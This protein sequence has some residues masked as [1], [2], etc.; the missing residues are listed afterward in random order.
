MWWSLGIGAAGNIAMTLILRTLGPNMMP[1][2][3]LGFALIPLRTISVPALSLGYI[4]R[5]IRLCHDPVWR[6]RL[7]RFGAGGRTALTT[8]L[9]QA[10]IGTTLFYGY[11]LALFGWGPAILLPMTVAIFTAQ[12]FASAWW[13]ERYRFGPVEWLWRRMTYP[14]E[15]PMRRERAVAGAVEGVA[16]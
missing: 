2:S 16:A 6:A 10:V 13:V 3:W 12:L 7:A 15:L 5:V 14:G 8:S 9:M 4:C 1:T 11:G